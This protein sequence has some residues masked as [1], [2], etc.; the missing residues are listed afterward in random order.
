VTA[1][2]FRALRFVLPEIDLSSPEGPGL[3]HSPRGGVSTVA[4]ADSVRQALLLLISTRPGERVNR[5]TYGCDLHRLVFAPADDTT[6]G[7]AM[8]YVQ[9]AVAQWEPRVDVVALDAVPLIDP[10]AV[11][12]QLTYRL[13]STAAVDTLAVTMPLGE[14]GA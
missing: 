8:H 13:K 9:Q 4:G 3:Q 5:A 12:I 14:S 6:A 2:R 7:L 10:P 11:E 1:P